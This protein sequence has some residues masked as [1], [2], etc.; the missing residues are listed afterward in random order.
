VS[1][2]WP[3][4]HT[5]PSLRHGAFVPSIGVEGHHKCRDTPRALS[6][7]APKLH[8]GVKGVVE[9]HKTTNGN[10]NPPGSDIPEGRAS[11]NT[12]KDHPCQTRIRRKDLASGKK[13]PPP[14][15]PRLNSQ[16]RRDHAH[17]CRHL[18]NHGAPTSDE[19]FSSN[20]D[21]DT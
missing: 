21:G 8:E 5:Q 17:G 10:P 2:V 9:R 11:E 15:L 18:Q 12:R 1:L 6:H 4:G 13:K 3:K 7:G 14:L 20:T 19:T 16:W